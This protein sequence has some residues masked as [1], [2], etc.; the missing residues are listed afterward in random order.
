MNKNALLGFGGVVVGSLLGFAIARSSLMGGVGATT[1]E[2]PAG[3]DANLNASMEGQVVAVG[4]QT[5][6][7]AQLPEDVR[8][9]LYELTSQNYLRARELLESYA[10]RLALAKD[11]NGGMVNPAKVSPLAELL[12]DKKITDEDVRKSYEA[13]KKT[14][15]PSMTFE[16]IAKNLR[17][18][19]ETQ[20]NQD[21]IR[22]TMAQ[23]RDKKSYALLLPSPCGPRVAMDFNKMPSRGDTNAKETLVAVGDFFCASC[24]YFKSDLENFLEKHREGIRYTQVITTDDVN[25]P[26]AQLAAGAYCAKRQSNDAF[27][28]YSERAYNTPYYLLQ[29]SSTTAEVRTQAVK[30]ATDAGL[31]AKAFEKCM[32]SEDGLDELKT[33]VASLKEA[34]ANKTPTY[35]A[36]GRR[37]VT[38]N[39]PSVL[40]D[41]LTQSFP[42]VVKAKEA[43][44]SAKDKGQ[45][46]K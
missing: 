21:G 40:I 3:C 22:R 17:I 28:K 39:N 45:A 36:S 42:G 34:G 13:N 37:I 41:I 23:L 24:R 14:F 11:K 5:V 16:S 27:W 26:I 6:A 10:A 46:P 31:D 2:A 7:G 30:L 12:P 29:K 4:N 15:P 8:A 32:T 19:L 18:H 20:R 9:E 43:A 44:Q 33:V 38:P 1:A 35:I 25:A